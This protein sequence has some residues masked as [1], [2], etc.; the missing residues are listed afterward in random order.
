MISLSSIPNPNTSLK[1]LSEG[2]TDEEIQTINNTRK[3]PDS[4]PIG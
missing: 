3:R 2:E 1:I 4:N